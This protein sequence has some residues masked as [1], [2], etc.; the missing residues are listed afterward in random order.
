VQLNWSCLLLSITTYIETSF[1][2][3]FA[4]SVIGHQYSEYKSI[5]L[6]AEATALYNVEYNKVTARLLSLDLFLEVPLS[7]FVDTNEY[8]H[9]F[10]RD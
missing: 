7:C 6:V 1:L 3:S 2:F 4:T 10:Y 5:A 9:K 8:I